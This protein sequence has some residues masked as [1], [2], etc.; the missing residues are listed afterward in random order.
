M[1][2][3]IMN[4]KDGIQ[5][6]KEE[7]KVKTPGGI[8]SRSLGN[9]AMVGYFAK[10]MAEEYFPEFDLMTWLA[11]AMTDEQTEA[12]EEDMVAQ[13]WDGIAGLQIG[14]RPGINGNHVMVKD[15]KLYIWYAEVHKLVAGNS[16]G[17]DAREAFSRGAVR[18][19]LVEEPYYEGAAT[20]RM[21]ATNTTRRCLVFDVKS[22]TVP[23]EFTA[24]VETARNTL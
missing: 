11:H 19:A 6:Y 13:F 3:D 12:V 7:L 1:A 9:Y 4:V 15:D 18:D 23:Q 17:S 14:D 21:G 24:V 22:I 2:T 8:S 20:M 16:R 10:D 5:A